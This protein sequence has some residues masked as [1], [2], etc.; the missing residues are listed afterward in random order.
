MKHISAKKL[1]EIFVRIIA[2]SKLIRKQRMRFPFLGNFIKKSCSLARIFSIKNIEN[3]HFNI[4][5]C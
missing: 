4:T 3:A 2:E 5:Q 1:Y